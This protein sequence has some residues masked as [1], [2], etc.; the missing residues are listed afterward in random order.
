M[1]CRRAGDR[2]RLMPPY[3][4]KDHRKLY[5]FLAAIVLLLDQVSKMI[6]ANAIPL[7]GS[8]TVIPGFF[9]ISHVL[10]RGA[11][12]SLFANSRSPYTGFM[13]IAF[14]L[15]VM[16]VISYMLWNSRRVLT[17]TTVGLS[18]ILGG[19]LGNLL[20]RVLLGSVVDFL[21]FQ[22]GTYHWPDFNIADSAIVIGSLLLLSDVFIGSG[23]PERK[24]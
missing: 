16:A 11:A 5:F 1:F 2:S 14:S 13:L 22:F 18:L 3:L 23:E 17:L 21:A 12:F 15:L 4:D 7:H 9:Q 20:D 10:N 19:A 24:P 8:V 6:V